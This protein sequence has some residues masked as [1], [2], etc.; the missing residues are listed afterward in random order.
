MVKLINIEE[1]G[2]KMKRDEFFRKIYRSIK[3]VLKGK[4]ET[5]QYWEKRYSSGGNSGAGSYGRLALY[6]A[7][8]IN[9]FVKE[10]SVQ[11]VIEFGC[12][13]GNQLSL[14]NYPTYI[15]FDVSETAIKICEKRFMSDATKSFRML[16][17]Y[18]G[19]QADL[20]LSLEVIF[21]L[22][23][24]NLYFE[25]MRILFNTSKRFI[26]IFSSNSDGNIDY[27]G[28]H[29]RQWRF[30]DWVDQNQP[31]WNLTQHIHNKYPYNKKTKEGS[32]SDFY[33]YEKNKQT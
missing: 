15:G 29:M 2:L 1:K 27:F 7:E 21:H 17:D 13:D 31:G 26:I 33:I 10:N 22:L 24:E 19:E 32:I 18:Q 23:E 28:T 9:R 25:H 4:I 16:G 11:S 8:I 12:G 30:T 6:K 14:A 5:L 3:R 20:T